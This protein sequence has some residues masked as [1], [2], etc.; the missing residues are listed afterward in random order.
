[1]T[2]QFVIDAVAPAVSQIIAE[3]FLDSSQTPQAE[4][5][6]AQLVF[7]EEPVA[8][9]SLSPAEARETAEGLAERVRQK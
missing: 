9:A 4:G 6:L 8:S 2:Y 3:H 1:M 5:D 7:A